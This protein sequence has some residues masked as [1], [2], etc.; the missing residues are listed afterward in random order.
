M[1]Q[2]VTR[3]GEAEDATEDQGEVDVSD[4]TGLAISRMTYTRITGDATMKSVLGTPIRMYRSILVPV[5]P[6][7][8]YWVQRVVLNEDLFHGS[9]VYFLDVWDY[10]ST[11]A[12]IDAAVDRLK[13]LL[14]EWRFVTAGNEVNGLIKWFSGGEIPT[15]RVGVMH[16]ATQW[17]LRIGA[18]RDIT[19][20]VEA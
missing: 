4:E 9:H 11:P 5:D 8:P 14:H 13:I 3:A 2:A 17:T 6:D 20:I 16:Y 1:A 7:M 19:N 12:R 10:G 18:A 15:D